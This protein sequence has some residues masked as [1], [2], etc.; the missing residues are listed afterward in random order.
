MPIIDE[1]VFILGI[2]YNLM[3][4]FR[5]TLKRHWNYSYKR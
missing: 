5:Q 4:T 2:V 3:Q 1:T